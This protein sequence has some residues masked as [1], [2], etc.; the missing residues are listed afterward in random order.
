MRFLPITRAISFIVPAVVGVVVMVGVGCTEPTVAPVSLPDGLPLADL[1]G[2]PRNLLRVTLEIGDNILAESDVVVDLDDGTLSG[3]LD[4]NNVSGDG[5]HAAI[6]RAYSRLNADTVEVLLGEARTTMTVGAAGDAFLDF[7][8]VSFE[9]CQA[10]GD[11]SCA[12]RFDANRNGFKNFDDLVASPAVDPAPQAP[13][14]A[15]APSTLQFSSGIRLGTFARQIVVLENSGE[16][17]MQVESIVIAGGQGVGA[18][19]FDPILG[20]AGV[21]KR[22][23]TPEELEDL[24][25]APGAEL[26]VAVS[27][28]PVNAFVASANL[29]VVARDT[30]TGVRQ[31]QRSK[32]LAN[33]DGALRPIDAAYQVP[34]LPGSI[35]LGGGGSV[36]IKAYPPTSLFSGQSVLSFDSA[37]SPGIPKTGATLSVDGIVMPADAAFW[38]DVRP[39]ERFAASV[40]GLASDIDVA[41]VQI[42]EDSVAREVVAVSRNAGT[43]AEAVEF[44]ND[45]ATSKTFLV[46]LGRL[47]EEDEPAEA[48]GALVAA[49]RAPVEVICTVTKGPE[50]DDEAPIGPDRGPIEGGISVQVRGRGFLPGATVT[51]ADTPAGDVTVATDDDGLATLTLTLPPGSLEVGKNPATIVVENPSIE[52]GGDGQAATL[53]AGFTYNPPRPGLVRLTPDFAPTTGTGG[54]VE[55]SGFFFSN[56]F[57]APRVTFDG[58]GND[59]VSVDAIFI[60]A[61]TLQVQ[62]PPHSAGNVNVTVANAIEAGAYG[63]PSEPRAFQYIQPVGNAPVLSSVSPAAGSSDGGESVTLTGTDFSATPRV[64]FGAVEG[65]VLVATS[66]SITVRTPTQS[67]D[68]AVDV[69]VVN[70]DG[71]TGSLTAAFTLTF[72]AP[73]I[74]IVTPNVGVDSGGTPVIVAGGG[75]RAGV[76]ARF[77]RTGQAAVPALAVSRLSAT[78]LLV[79][80]PVLTAGPATLVVRNVDGQEASAAFSFVTPSGPAPTISFLD[81]ESGGVSGNNPVS[82]FGAGFVGARVFFADAEIAAETIEFIAGDGGR[83]DE[84]R[85]SA[86]PA[87]AVGTVAV[88]LVNDDGQSAATAYTY[89]L[90]ENPRISFASPDRVHTVGNDTLNIFGENLLTLGATPTAT[91]IVGA[92]SVTATVRGISDTLVA[93]QLRNVSLPAGVTS[94]TATLRLQG[95]GR[96]VTTAA[97]T[98]AAPVPQEVSI[99][100]GRVEIFGS[101]LNGARLRDVVL[102][103]STGPV[104]CVPTI[105]ADFFVRCTPASTPNVA[106]GERLTVALSYNNTFG[107]PFTSTTAN[108]PAVV[109]GNALAGG[110]G[111]GIIDVVVGETCDS[112]DPGCLECQEIAEPN[113]TIETATLAEGPPNGALA[114]TGDVDHY[115]VE[116]ISGETVFSFVRLDGSPCNPSDSIEVFTAAGEN[117]GAPLAPISGRCAEVRVVGISGDVVLRVS[118]PGSAPFHYGVNADFQDGPGIR[119]DFVN[120]GETVF[121]PDGFSMEGQGL[122]GDVFFD[123]E[124]DA[125]GA[126][127]SLPTE[128]LSETAVNVPSSSGIA[129]GAWRGCANSACS[130]FFVAAPFAEI[131]PNDFDGQATGILEGAPIEATGDGTLDVFF[132]LP[133][134]DLISVTIDATD[135]IAADLQCGGMFADVV[136]GGNPVDSV[137]LTDCEVVTL[138]NILVTFGED[139]FVEV[140]G[141]P[142]DLVYRVTLN[143]SDDFDGD[144]IPDLDDLAPDDP[145]VPNP[146]SPACGGQGGEPICGNGAVEAGEACDA[147][148]VGVGCTSTCQE[149][150][151]FFCTHTEGSPSV[152]HAGVCNEDPLTGPLGTGFF[153]GGNGVSISAAGATSNADRGTITTDD[154]EFPVVVEVDLR[155]TS[156]GLAFV[157]TRSAGEPNT[158]EPDGS[159]YARIHNNVGGNNTMSLATSSAGADILDQSEEPAEPRSLNRLYH[160]R[161]VDDG[162]FTTSTWTDLEGDDPPVVVSAP[163]DGFPGTGNKAVLSGDAGVT[164]SNL[165]VCSAATFIPVANGSFEEVAVAP[166]GQVTGVDGWS[167][168]ADTARPNDFTPIEGFQTMVITPGNTIS[169]SLPSSF[170]PDSRVSL[171]GIV[172]ARPLSESVEITGTFGGETFLLPIPSVEGTPFRHDIEVAPGSP[173][174]GQ[175]FSI[176]FTGGGVGVETHIDAVVLRSQSVVFTPDP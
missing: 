87:A 130:G 31:G 103:T 39:G 100:G 41:L 145:C 118:S 123:F 91:L 163:S 76:T 156:G 132:A 170:Q 55:L 84:L 133:T 40:A 101:D 161:F 83:L 110:C 141:I 9:G 166:G 63:T 155:W 62:P 33:V 108:V 129:P 82:I 90:D 34:E 151:G 139:V 153:T 97:F 105:R 171:M 5:E 92:Q 48:E 80:T 69:R 172:F 49:E 122:Q 125:T 12:L 22:Q 29:Q 140:G 65:T 61:D 16:N 154:L 64:F 78:S 45:A 135:G 160:V 117:V 27:F 113:D 36:P 96:T 37:A 116:G 67:R 126:L 2:A 164:F 106:V 79:T 59:D 149:A 124:H 134:T 1:Q 13:F 102:T 14:V 25:V 44:L 46:V 142:Q 85:V 143:V 47:D 121:W 53:P 89:A 66:T 169:Q 137:A 99:N 173:Q 144:G 158:S 109:V 35:S 165:R 127:R 81:P 74:N 157:G 119:I 4:L 21:P 10:T 147:G 75:F 6:L 159:L 152:C 77:V 98:I 120:N 148:G 15:L 51:F 20:V 94:S 7:D 24:V 28:A 38:V 115:L 23:I 68:G 104:A 26:F 58:Q 57:G 30:V 168:V 138:Q 60:S 93:V 52:N 17:P 146:Q 32:I 136:V 8:G 43:S 150:L 128:L 88:R 56:R 131:E 86:P 176:A 19:L 114:P 107:A 18:S 112:A 95:R 11:G 70:P 3:N 175:P 111:D 72:A 174:A 73:A 71:Q 162:F 167:G 42:D 50:F 54:P